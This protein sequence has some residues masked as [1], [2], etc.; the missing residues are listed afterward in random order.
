MNPEVTTR[1]L[2]AV[3]VIGSALL[4][5]GLAQRIWLRRAAVRVR[6]LRDY[7][8][9]HPAILYFT[10]PTCA[11]CKTVQRPAIDSL[12]ERLGSDLQV[13]EIDAS[14]H[15]DLA[16]DWGVLSV[17]T[18]FVIDP[19]GQPRHV[20]HGVATAEKLYSQLKEII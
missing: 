14:S 7:Q 15:P 3:T 20:N 12:K 17:P 1:L 10:T 11:P 8:T 4:A 2:V 5:Y 19:L 18:T 9:G 13:L 16:D 6:G